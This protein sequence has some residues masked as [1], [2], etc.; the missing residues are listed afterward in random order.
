MDPL[1]TSDLSMIGTYSKVG[2]RNGASADQV[3]AEA[4]G[5]VPAGPDGEP[6]RP[7]DAAQRPAATRS[8]KSP[9]PRPTEVWKNTSPDSHADEATLDDESFKPEGTLPDAAPPGVEF[10]EESTPGQPGRAS[11]KRA[12]Q[13]PASVDDPFADFGAFDMGGASQPISSPGKPAG[14]DGSLSFELDEPT[15]PP[16]PSGDAPDSIF[17][18][19]ERSGLFKSPGGDGPTSPEQEPPWEFG[20]AAGDPKPGHEDAPVTFQTDTISRSKGAGAPQD[21]LGLSAGKAVNLEPQ[22][23]GGPTLDDI[24]FASLLDDVPGDSKEKKGTE[25]FFVDSP[26]MTGAQFEAPKS[27]GDSFSM[28][29]ITFDDLDSLAAPAGADPG[30]SK[31]AA[32]A[33]AAAGDDM[34]ELDMGA[35]G[36]DVALPKLETESLPRPDL[37]PDGATG[38]RSR[39]IRRKASPLVAVV[40]IGVLAVGGYGAYE[41]GFLDSLFGNGKVEPQQLVTQKQDEKKSWG[42]RL[43][44]STG[45]LDERIQALLKEAEIRPESKIEVDEELFWTLAWYKF[46]FPKQFAIASIPGNDKETLQARLDRLRKAHADAVFKVRLESME[47]A[48]EGKYPEAAT[49]F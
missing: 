24:D 17:T 2:E 22:T 30:K 7:A 11:A 45:E 48:A 25:V 5:G 35:A 6:A 18:I 15:T 37:R 29:E 36:V 9:E 1:S 21:T 44:A 42:L 23:G 13:A 20:D 46:L 16:A 47:L 10:L 27:A 34:F 19:E 32:A 28:E 26:S 8:P 33:P 43:L 12:P 31:P 3:W 4:P 39:S 40:I 41:F 49:A 14:A 38:T